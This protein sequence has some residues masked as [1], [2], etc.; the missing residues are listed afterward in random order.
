MSLVTSCLLDIIA[1]STYLIVHIYKIFNH[2]TVYCSTLQLID[3]LLNIWQQSI[4][5]CFY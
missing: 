2:A 1:A 5:V 3:K 4:N